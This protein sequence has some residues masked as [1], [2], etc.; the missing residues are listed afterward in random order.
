MDQKFI[1]VTLLVK[2]GASAA[3]AAALVRSREFHSRLFHEEG[4]SLRETTILTV[5][6]AIP[7]GLGVQVRHMV[8]NFKAADLAFE[9]TI[10]MGVIGGV[11][12]GVLGGV[13]VAIPAVLHGEYLTLL[14]N[15]FVGLI[16]GGLRELAD[17]WADKE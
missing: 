17:K 9:A 8:A 13:L 4:R 14:F 16:A 10:I 1:L 5:A 12:A 2:L 3:I 11:Y 15:I 7:Y 6:I